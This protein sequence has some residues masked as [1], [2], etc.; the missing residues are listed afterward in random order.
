[1]KSKILLIKE[2][3]LKCYKYHKKTIIFLVIVGLFVLSFLLNIQKDNIQFDNEVI[4]ADLILE[5]SEEI[6][7]TV[8]NEDEEQNIVIEKLKVDV[9]GYVNNPGVY[10]LDKGSR[11]IDAILKSGG[12]SENADTS[13]INL[14]KKLFD[15]MVIIVRDRDYEE[16]CELDYYDLTEEETDK[17]DSK[18]D[19]N[20]KI[21]ITKATKEELMTVPGIGD[22]KADSIIKYRLNVGFSKI[23][24]IKNVKGIGATTFESIKDFITL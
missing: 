11:I 14:S 20:S 16:K 5:K 21:S 22:I 3:F 13:N 6:N 17:I 8:N 12:L 24:D 1:M 9:K 4:A 2:K 18:D 19:G 10:E 7:T 23:E 15:E